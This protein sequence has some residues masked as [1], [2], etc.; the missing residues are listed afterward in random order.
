MDGS[1]QIEQ[2]RNK[3]NEIISYP[4]PICVG[5]IKENI[6]ISTNTAN[7]PSKE[8]IINQ[9][10]N[11]HLQGEISEAAKYY[12][13]CID[14]DFNDPRVF[15]NYGIILKDLGKLKEAEKSQLKAIELKPDSATAHS[16]LGNVLK[17]LGKLKEAEKS[18]LKAIEFKPH[19]AD[20]YCNLGSIQIDLGNLHQ[21]EI[22]TRKAIE[23]RPDYVMAYQ[24]LGIILI[25]LGRLKEAEELQLKIIE[26]KPDF[27]NAY[28]NLGNILIDLGRLKEAE[29]S[30]RKA[31]ELK[32]DYAEAHSNLGS[33][34]RDLGQLKDAEISFHKAIELNPDL[35]KTYF[36][37]STLEYSN[38]NNI[39]KDYLFSESILNNNLS[40]GRVDIYF[41]RSN[42]LHREMNYKESSNCL[43]SAN[44]I[45]LELKPSKPQN[46]FNKSNELLIGSYKEDLTSIS[47]LEPI[48]CIFIVGMP[49][50]GSTLVESILSMNID[51]DD[52]G[53]VN[54]L[55]ESFIEWKKFRAINKKLNFADLYWSKASINENQSLITTDKMLDNYQYSGIILSQIPYA[56][57]IHCYRNPLDNILSIFRANFATGNEYASSLSDCARVYLN[58][59][60]KMTEYKKKYRTKIYDLN[61]DLLVEDPNTEI[62]KLIYWLGWEWEDNYLSP[63]LNPRS[64]VTASSVQVR[65]PINSKSVGGWMNYKEMLQPAIEVLEKTEKY[66][67][68]QLL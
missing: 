63:Q 29:E 49:R 7:K 41:A 58:Q 8:Q 19:F 14:Q 53:E 34:L 65:S 25:D 9:A 37:L 10:I 21:A 5:E 1:G 24:N 43:K 31:I 67:N 15:S 52:I 61:Y 55:E 23:L 60:A 3:V 32:P 48:E 36:A 46:L 62:R 20:A 13:Y 28:F 45:K 35:A 66:K 11:Y 44:K 26:L 59:E 12:Q 50:C 4:V 38:D 27:P 56:K 64:V 57:I 42:I 2:G 6:S 39:W 47:Q 30:Q 54:F 17:L 22:S 18:Q 40:E 51:V 68:L 33:I 16:N